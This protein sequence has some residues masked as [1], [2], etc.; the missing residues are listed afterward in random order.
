MRTTWKRVMAV[1]TVSSLVML[2]M[3]GP[4]QADSHT[5]SNSWGSGSVQNLHR[6]VVVCDKNSNN[7]GLRIEYKYGPNNAS[8]GHRGDSDGNNGLC[9][10]ATTSEAINEFRICESDTGGGNDRCTNWENIVG[11]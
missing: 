4:A 10:S 2:G 7:R 6:G 8:S 5:H 1:G 9:K 3:T 11:R